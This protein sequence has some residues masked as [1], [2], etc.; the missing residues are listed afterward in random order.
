MAVSGRETRGHAT[1]VRPGHGNRR[2]SRR[3]LN[4]GCWG[5]MGPNVAVGP[6][7]NQNRCHQTRF[8]R[9]RYTKIGFWPDLYP[10]RRYES[11]QRSYTLQ[12][13]LRATR[14]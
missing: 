6:P 5:R 10:G 11:L 14:Q 2:H 3:K 1:P 13:D 9:S 4:S 7:K 8:M 12:L